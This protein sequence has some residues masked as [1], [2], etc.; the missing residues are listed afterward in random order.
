[1][2]RSDQFLGRHGSTFDQIPLANV[3]TS[4]TIN[5]PAAVIWAMYLAVAEKQGA[6]WKRISGTLQNDILKEYIAQKEYIYPPEPS[7]RLVIDTIRVRSKTHAQVQYDFDQRLPHSA[8][9]LDGDSGTGIYAA[10][11]LEYVEWGMRRGLDVDEFVP[12]LSFFFN[13][14]SDFFEKSPS[15][16]PPRASGTKPW[17]SGTDRTIRAP[18]RCVSIPKRPAAR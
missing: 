17:S 9:R 3:T 18:G 16:G 4:M 15:I 12:Q 5:S 14:H 11:R 2:R 13:A 6:G 10:R 7:M 1:M 8:S